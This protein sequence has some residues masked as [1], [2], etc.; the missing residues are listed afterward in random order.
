MSINIEFLLVFAS[1]LVS[2]DKVDFTDMNILFF[3]GKSTDKFKTYSVLDLDEIASHPNFFKN[4][5][6]MLYIHGYR[7]NVT[8]IN[9]Q[10]MVKAFL[11]RGTHNTLALNWSAYAK[12]NYITFAV[13][14]LIRIAQLIAQSVFKLVNYQVI[15]VSKMHSNF[16]MKLIS[17]YIEM[18]IFFFFLFLSHRT[19]TWWSNVRIHWTLDHC[20][21]EKSF[22]FKS[23]ISS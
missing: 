8:G 20:S 12:G 18:T 21:F 2:S 15:E 17:M 14:N 3:Y 11:N 22:P 7:D 13:P 4:K 19:F 5:T 23:N 16:P 10:T 6:T 1:Y 9:V